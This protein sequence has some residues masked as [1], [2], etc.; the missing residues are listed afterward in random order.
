M[1]YTIR[2]A[3]TSDFETIFALIREFAEFQKTPEKVKITVAE[4]EENKEVFHCLVAEKENQIIGFATFFP[5]YYSWIGKS[6]YLDDLYVVEAFQGNGIGKKLIEEVIGIA[7]ADGYKK[8]RWQ[9]SNWNSK[10]IAFYKKLGA[11]IDQTEINCDLL[12]S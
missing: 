1:N 5:A 3:E 10:A 11:E 6:M 2:K 8:V 7:K 9:V 12:I 4:M